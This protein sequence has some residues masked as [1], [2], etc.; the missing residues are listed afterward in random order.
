MAAF[1]RRGAAALLTA[2]AVLVTS[3]SPA[4][5]VPQEPAEPEAPANTQYFGYQVDEQL[6]T[7]NS[8][9][10]EGA[11][12]N[13]E[14]LSARLYPSVYVPGP[15]GEMI[16]NTDL[17]TAQSLPGRQRQVVYTLNQD[18]TFSDG[19]PITCVDFL[20]AHTAGTL[21]SIF[22]SH[23]PLMQQ[24]ERIDCDPGDRQFTAVFNAGEGGRWRQVFGPG[25]VLPAHTIARSSGLSMEELTEALHAKDAVALEEVAR[26]WNEGFDLASFDPELQ[27][28]SGPFKVSEVGPQGEVVLTRNENY[29]GDSA[30]LETLVVW[31]DSADAQELADLGALRVADVPDSEPEFVNRD[32]PS[33]PYLIETRVGDLTESLKLSETGILGQQ[34]ARQAFAGCVD[35]NWSAAVSSDVSGI[36]VPPVSTQVLHHFDPTARQLAEVSNPHLAIDHAAASALAGSTIRIGYSGPDPRKAAIVQVLAESCA[37]A[38]ITVVDASEEGS[39]IGDLGRITTGQWGENQYLEGT[40]DAYLGAIDP[41]TEYGA[42]VAADSDVN[43]LREAETQA[44]EQLDYIPLAAQPRAFVVDERV[45]NVVVYTGLAGIGWNMDRWSIQDQDGSNP[46]GTSESGSAEPAEQG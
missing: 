9:S 16:P 46:D 27:V 41:M 14:V 29:H 32:D 39:G 5:D 17:A 15:S 44:W 1:R 21:T 25:T 12:N 26:V 37:P 28:S 33:N 11:S 43:Q 30:R 45:S 23:M 22:D 40:I 42:V 38:G 34:W 35:Q 13:S 7:T 36:E 4:E 8:G 2:L 19:Q 10:I 6:V 3:C 20:L 31:P 24:I 18:A